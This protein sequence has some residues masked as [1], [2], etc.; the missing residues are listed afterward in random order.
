MRGLHQ[1]R[2]AHAARAPQQRIVGRQALGEALG[3]LD[4]HV[5]HAVDALEQRHLDAVDARDRREPASVRLPDEGVGAG[6]IGH[7]RALRRQPLERGGDAREHV[8]VAG[9]RARLSCLELRCD[10]DF[11]FAMGPFFKVRC[12]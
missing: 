11:D 7:G 6:Q 9:A 4:Q 12:S 2:L 3:I 5:A 1:R 10:L 8:G